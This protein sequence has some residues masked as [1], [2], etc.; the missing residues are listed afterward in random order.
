MIRPRDIL[1]TARTLHA[2][3]DRNPADLSVEALYRSAVSRSYYSVLMH[4]KQRLNVPDP[5]RTVG[6]G[7]HEL[8]MQMLLEQEHAICPDDIRVA[9]GVAPTLRE[10]RVDADYKLELTIGKAESADAIQRAASVFRVAPA[11]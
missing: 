2:V 5:D 6:I 4:V 8:V 9:K 3:A 10:A 1:T 7:T 11:D